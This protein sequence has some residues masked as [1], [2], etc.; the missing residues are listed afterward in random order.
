MGQTLDVRYTSALREIFLETERAKKKFPKDFATKHHGYAVLLEEVDELWNDIKKDVTDG[1]DIKEAIQV[2][3]MALRYVAEFGNHSRTAPVYER[4]G[5]Q[6]HI[7]KL[8][9]VA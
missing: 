5:A 2:A 9:M 8:L 3:A 6:H 4:S 1:S 7:E